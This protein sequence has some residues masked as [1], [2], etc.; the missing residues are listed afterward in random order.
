MSGIKRILDHYDGVLNGEPWHGD[1]VWPVLD[2]ISARE[3][4]ARPIPAVHTIWEIVM[5]MA[6][7][8]NVAVQRLSGLRAGL[9]EELNFPP[10]PAATEEN[11]R[12]TLDQFRDSNRVFRQSLAKLDEE[13]LDELTAAGK[14][15][16]YGE[17]HGIIEH[18]VYHLGQI[19]LVKKMQA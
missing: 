16:F 10:M 9:V 4:A 14:R 12:K 1:A 2:S 19:V 5:H 11:W 6:F 13:R 18:H 15:T 8:E 7:W 3:A 17:A